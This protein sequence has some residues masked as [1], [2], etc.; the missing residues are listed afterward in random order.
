MSIQAV[1]GWSALMAHNILKTNDPN[2]IT[3]KVLGFVFDI[4]YALVSITV[5]AFL[6]IFDKKVRGAFKKKISSAMHPPLADNLVGLDGAQLK[7]ETTKE[8]DIYFKQFQ[9]AWK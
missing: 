9:S 1:T 5:P 2:T 7:V 3:V 4:T 6:C 8:G